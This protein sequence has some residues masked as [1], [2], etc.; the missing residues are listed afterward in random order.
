MVSHC[1]EP[2]HGGLRN[3]RKFRFQ[4]SGQAAIAGELRATVASLVEDAKESADANAALREALQDQ[5]ENERQ[6][7]EKV[8]YRIE[9][10]C[11]IKIGRLLFFMKRHFICV[12]CSYLLCSNC[13]E[14][15]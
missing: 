13:V 3:T 8:K 7:T 6:T 4:L 11:G 2:R 9:W 12:A 14:G 15:W 10:Q 1:T 5:E